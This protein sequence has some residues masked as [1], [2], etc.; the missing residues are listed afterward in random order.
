MVVMGQ[1]GAL[2]T[3]L[4][5]KGGGLRNSLGSWVLSPLLAQMLRGISAVKCT[6]P[7]DIW[8]NWDWNQSMISVVLL[9]MPEVR[10]QHPKHSLW[11]L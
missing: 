5:P 11:E 7:Q 3:S 8:E 1:E 4:W 6:Y 2:G 9:L 10:G